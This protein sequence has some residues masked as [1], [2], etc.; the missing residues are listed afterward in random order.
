M[1]TL[2][3]TRKPAACTRNVPPPRAPKTARLTSR[4]VHPTESS[5]P[6]EPVA[7]RTSKPKAKATSLPVFHPDLKTAQLL[8][9]KNG[10]RSLPDICFE[11]TSKNRLLKAVYT[12]NHAGWRTASM[13]LYHR[14]SKFSSHWEPL[15]AW[16]TFAK[17]KA[18]I[19]S[20][21]LWR[22]PEVSYTREV[23][24]F[25]QA[26]MLERMREKVTEFFAKGQTAS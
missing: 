8:K 25:A 7:P 17:D 19:A 20:S 24:V 18:E 6:P 16:G 5:L 13:E 15:A 21:P 3:V 1:S 14:D 10:A 9:V 11:V 26:V 2:S 22:G 12:F 4:I 23:E